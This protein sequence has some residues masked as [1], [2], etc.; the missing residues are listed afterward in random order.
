MAAGRAGRVWHGWINGVGRM[1]DRDYSKFKVLSMSIFIGR[2]WEG[3][4]VNI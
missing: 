3:Q 4:L 1:V 2:S